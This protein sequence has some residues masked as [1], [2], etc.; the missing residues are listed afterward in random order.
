MAEVAAAQAA[1]EGA[2]KVVE[3]AKR[4]VTA[5]K[6]A[7]DEQKK[8]ANRW[9][10]KVSVMTAE[11]EATKRQLADAQAQAK[12]DRKAAEERLQAAAVELAAAEAAKASVAQGADVAKAAVASLKL[13]LAD[14]RTKSAIWLERVSRATN[15]AGKSKAALAA[16]QASAE[17][18]SAAT[19]AQLEAAATELAQMQAAKEA[20]SGEVARARAEVVTLKGEV[21]EH[22]SKA[23]RWIEKVRRVLYGVFINLDH[24]GHDVP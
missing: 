5:L 13:E 19:K 11:S 8:K 21:A 1:K 14:Q 17:A 7:L 4:E 23:S 6:S 12:A 9:V 2:S 15:E 3:H 24:E 16:A 20:A 18:E 10:E 22:K